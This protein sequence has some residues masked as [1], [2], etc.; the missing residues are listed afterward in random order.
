MEA[1]GWVSGD[2]KLEAF[3]AANVYCLPSYNEGLPV[4]VLEA[5]ACGLPVVSTPIAGI[6]EAVIE[7]ETGHLVETGDSSTLAD[8]LTA[9]LADP[10]AAHAMGKNGRARAERLFALEVVVEQLLRIWTE[11]LEASSL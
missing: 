8:K 2:S 3:K 4:S 1:L 5:M 7:G 6:P 10:L 11:A 9:L